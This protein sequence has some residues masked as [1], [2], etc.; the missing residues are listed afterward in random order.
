MTFSHS[1]GQES[2]G[3]ISAIAAADLIPDQRRLGYTRA[4]SEDTQRR[5]AAIV[6]S[7][8]IGWAKLSQCSLIILLAL[9][10]ALSLTAKPVPAF[11]VTGLQAGD[12]RSVGSIGNKAGIAI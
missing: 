1:L 11:N 3:G 12:S 2:P 7:H 5:F 10:F 6:A 4:M 9:S 8:A